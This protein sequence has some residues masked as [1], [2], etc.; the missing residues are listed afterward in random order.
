MTAPLVGFGRDER[1]AGE[2]LALALVAVEPHAFVFAFV[3]L[4]FHR[5]QGT[6]GAKAHEITRVPFRHAAEGNAALPRR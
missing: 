2:H 6:A 4:A 5:H 1:L 3:V